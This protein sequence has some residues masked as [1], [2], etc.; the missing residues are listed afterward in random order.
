[1]EDTDHLDVIEIIAN[2]IKLRDNWI[3][4][5]AMNLEGAKKIVRL[6]A[7]VL[8]HSI[9]DELVDEEFIQLLKEHNVVYTPNLI[10]FEGYRKARNVLMGDTI[11]L[12]DPNNVLDQRTKDTWNN[13]YSY[14][15]LL[16]SAQFTKEALQENLE[17][18]K[19]YEIALSNLKTVY[20][21]G[22]LI[23]TGTDAGNPGT[24]HG[25][26][27]VQELEMLQDAGIPPEEILV[28]ATRN[29]SLTM[30]K[31]KIIGTLEEGKIADLVIMDENPSKDISNIRTMTHVMHLGIL[32]SVK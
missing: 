28:M 15:A 30:R 3:V 2:E 21:A 11:P 16:D 5:H 19:I 24:H 22:I 20:D 17:V 10:V 8:V 27:F 31:E 23:S 4:A 12:D 26:S 7:K 13:S 18:D 6:G 9:T 29:G 32:R 1:M 25:I 14:F